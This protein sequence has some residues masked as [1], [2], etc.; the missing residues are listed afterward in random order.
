MF[1]TGR[2]IKTKTHDTP[3][4]KLETGSKVTKSLVSAG[5]RIYGTVNGSVLSRNVI[6]EPGAVVTDS[7]IMQGTV[8]KSGAVVDH[9]I[10]DRN[11]VI[12]AGTMLKGT[13]DD[14]L[15]LGK[16]RD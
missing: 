8:V 11:N 4:A 16:A 2:Y 14:V 3:P 1:P 10:I 12:P 6:I 13:A 5:C 9:A 7:I 15:A